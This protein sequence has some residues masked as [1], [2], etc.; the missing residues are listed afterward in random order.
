M[1][2]T[3]RELTILTKRGIRENFNPEVLT[4]CLSSCFV[5]RADYFFFGGARNRNFLAVA[6]CLGSDFLF[7]KLVLISSLDAVV[8]G[9]RSELS[10]R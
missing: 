8:W 3:G 9:L 6:V 1:C 4:Y 7:L 10:S 5:R 2:E